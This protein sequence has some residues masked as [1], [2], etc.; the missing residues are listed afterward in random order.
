MPEPL[1]QTTG[2]A[3]PTRRPG[4]PVSLQKRQAMCDAAIAEFA[5]SGYDSASVDA[6]AARA[7][8]S[9]RTLYNHFPS[10]ED[11][12]KALVSEVGL[13]ISVPATLRYAPHIPLR[14]QVLRFVRETLALVAEAQTLQLL[15]TVL[16]E[17]LRH[18]ERVEPILAHYWRNEYGFIAWAEAACADGRLRGDPG[19]IGHALTS[20]MRAHVFWPM[21]LGRLERRTGAFDAEISEAV[22]MFL[23]YYGREAG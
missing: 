7:Q 5:Q 1:V 17:H 11:L 23:H 6:I 21:L 22:D 18:P 12:F 16:A 13:R 14:E 9:K 8:V 20:M 3:P 2:A 10:K 4:R 15:R 19:K